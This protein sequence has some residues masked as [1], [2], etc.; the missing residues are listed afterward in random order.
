MKRRLLSSFDRT[1]TTAALDSAALPFECPE[2]NTEMPSTTAEDDGAGGSAPP[3]PLRCVRLYVRLPLHLRLD[4]WPFAIVYAVLGEAA[5]RTAADAFEATLIVGLGLL[6]HAL[7]VL[8]TH[9]SVGGGNGVGGGGETT[10]GWRV[11]GCLPI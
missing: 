4:V 2:T 6:L 7:A 8:S 11:E 10:D 5:R 3:P 9:W 1:T